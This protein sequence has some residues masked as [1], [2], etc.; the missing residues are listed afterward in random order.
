MLQRQAKVRLDK[1]NAA[2]GRMQHHAVRY[3]HRKREPEDYDLRSDPAVLRV[4]VAQAGRTRLCV[5]V[6]VYVC[7]YVFQTC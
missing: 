4:A 6:C 5:C 1:L 3:L 2:A 7:V